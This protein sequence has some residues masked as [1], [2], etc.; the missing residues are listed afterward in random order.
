M[1]WNE[2]KNIVTS[3]K[4]TIKIIDDRMYILEKLCSYLGSSSTTWAQVLSPS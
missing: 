3:L 1:I 2:E 4:E